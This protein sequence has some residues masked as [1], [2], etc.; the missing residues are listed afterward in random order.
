MS[1]K[2]RTWTAHARERLA[3]AFRAAA[4]GFP[5]SGSEVADIVHDARKD[6]KRAASLTRLFAPIVGAPAYGALDIADAARKAIARARDLDVLPSALERLKCAPESREILMRA[7]AAEREKARNAH[8]EIDIKRITAEL[9]TCADDIDGWD[10]GEEADEPLLNSLRQTFRSAKRRGR[11]A[12][13]TADADDLHALRARV[14]DLGQQIT[15]FESAWSALISAQ[16]LELHR[17]RTSLGD[18]N[19][20][21]VLGEFTL[22]R[23]ELSAAAVEAV[24]AEVLKRRKPLEH[25]AHEQYNRIFAERPGAF[26][27]RFAGYLAFP[28]KRV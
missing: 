27:R 13:A 17:L 3:A 6:L 10:L 7:I 2:R 5:R 18:H 28:Q 1:R 26:E 23:R 4:Q 16:A 9:L 25:R 12:W 21:T 22:S 8:V 24:V 20:L 15:L 11:I 14:V 19:D